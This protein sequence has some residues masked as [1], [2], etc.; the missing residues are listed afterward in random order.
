MTIDPRSETAIVLIFPSSVS[1]DER[2][3]KALSTVVAV[4]LR[5]DVQDTVYL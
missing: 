5:D 4:Y 2:R 1:V 3:R